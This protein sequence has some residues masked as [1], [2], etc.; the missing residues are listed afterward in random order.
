[1]SPNRRRFRGKMESGFLLQARRDL[2]LHLRVLGAWCWVLG[3][4][5]PGAWCWG[6]R[7]VL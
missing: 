1:M 4:L 5:V 6:P 7:A 3:C 2:K